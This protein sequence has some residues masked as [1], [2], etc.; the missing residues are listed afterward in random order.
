MGSRKSKV[1]GVRVWTGYYGRPGDRERG[2]VHIHIKG[3]GPAC[4]V[5]LHP[6]SQFQWCAQGVRLDYVECERCKAVWVRAQAREEA[7]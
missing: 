6:D 1:S 3:S 5:R 7:L 4:G 2:R